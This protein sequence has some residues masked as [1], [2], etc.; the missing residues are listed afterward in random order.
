MQEV[1]DLAILGV[2]TRDDSLEIG[3][4]LGERCELFLERRVVHQVF[5]SIQPVR[6]VSQ[7]LRLSYE[8]IVPRVDILGLAK[9]H[10]EPYP[11]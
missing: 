8:R 4:T 1:F 7:C 9:G 2:D 3:E 10:A 6:D 11:E 5:H